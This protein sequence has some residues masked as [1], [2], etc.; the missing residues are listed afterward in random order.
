MAQ[1]EDIYV[2]AYGIDWNAAMA[3][4]LSKISASVI[5]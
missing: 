5:R 2:R 1:V 4:M 3:S